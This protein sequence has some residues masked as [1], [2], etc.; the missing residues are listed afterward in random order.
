MVNETSA[1]AYEE[2]SESLCDRQQLV[3]N[4]FRTLEIA[5]NHMIS[6]YLNLPINNVTGRS[7]ELKNLK[8]LTF[9]HKALCPYTGKTTEFFKLTKFGENLSEP[10]DQVKQSRLVYRNYIVE[11]GFDTTVFKTC[12]RDIMSKEWHNVEIVKSPLGELRCICDC[13]DYNNNKQCKEDCKHITSLK[14]NLIKDSQL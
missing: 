2:I 4:A 11:E 7:C 6:K 5:N 14:Q 8:M 13:Y 10:I 9:S 1:M 12:S 3:L